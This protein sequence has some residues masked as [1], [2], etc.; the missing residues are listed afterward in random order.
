MAP[1][2]LFQ[3]YMLGDLK[4]SSRIVMS[5]M[6]RS[7]AEAD[8]SPSRYAAEYYGQRSSPGLVIAEA[9]QVG[10][11]ATG[12]PRTPGIWSDAQTVVWATVAKAIKKD[13]AKAFIQLW[14]TGRIAH[15]HNL[16]PGWDPIAPSP[17][18][19]KLPIYTDVAAGMVE[20]PVPREMTEE[21]IR[22]VLDD[23]RR[24]AAN[25]R[26]AGFDGIELHCANGYLI[27]Q[28]A[29]TNTNLRTDR[30]GGNLDKRLN[31]MRAVF[32][33]VADVYDRSRIGARL[34]P[35]GTF[36]EIDDADPAG[37]FRAQLE[38]VKA[39][40]LGYVHVIRPRVSG[41]E[42]RTASQADTDVVDIA[43]RSFP[44]TVIS[45][46]GY[47]AESAEAELAAGRSDLIAFGRPFIGNPDF[48]RRIREGLPL[49]SYN[50]Q[51]LYEPGP[52]G[53]IDYPA[54]S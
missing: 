22:R 4:L 48:P 44:G 38:V 5:P 52:A 31:F 39:A 19:P 21:D 11:D 23:H 26:K 7:R 47:T 6:T 37:K 17:V 29:S 30:W 15:Q 41:D 43:R 25:A 34:S 27:D 1:T 20:N 36:N 42:D 40:R 33:A 24:A 46:G 3:S 51:L 18:Q 53:Y 2:L 28:F 32:D 50:A 10:P 54:Y 12:Y 8:W 35:Y 13:G 9:T 16:P 49:A 45:A 14:H